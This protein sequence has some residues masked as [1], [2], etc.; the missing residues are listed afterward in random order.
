[1]KNKV[2]NSNVRDTPIGEA[3][4][5]INTVSKGIILSNFDSIFFFF[6]H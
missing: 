2:K 4:I 6:S 5:L 1:M 3:L